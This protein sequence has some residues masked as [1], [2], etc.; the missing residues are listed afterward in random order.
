M[1]K[2]AQDEI[3]KQS[4]LT[5]IDREELLLKKYT[6]YIPQ[7]N[8]KEIKELFNEFQEATS[9]HIDMLK[10]KLQKLNL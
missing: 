2:I 7:V 9:G 4:I 3:T 6:E 5:S 8:D 1:K 10:S